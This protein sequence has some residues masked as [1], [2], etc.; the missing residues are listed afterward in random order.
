MLMQFHNPQ[1]DLKAM[2]IF[3]EAIA[4]ELINLA[5]GLWDIL[6]SEHFIQVETPLIF[7]GREEVIGFTWCRPGAR[8]LDIW[9]RLPD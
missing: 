3:T 1:L 9:V 6:S 7:P 4:Q 2:L 8:R 5:Q